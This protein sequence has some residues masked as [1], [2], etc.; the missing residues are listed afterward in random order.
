MME[1]YIRWN[2]IKDIKSGRI[3][4]RWRNGETKIGKK[5]RLG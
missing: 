1:K 5:V 3:G 4:E 2:N